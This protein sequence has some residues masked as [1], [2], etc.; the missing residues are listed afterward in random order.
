MVIHFPRNLA[1]N[2]KTSI[3]HN[4]IGYRGTKQPSFFERIWCHMANYAHRSRE[5]S[6]LGKY[7]ASALTHA[8]AA[9][10]IVNLAIDL[11]ETDPEHGRSSKLH[12]DGERAYDAL[13]QLYYDLD[14]AGCDLE[15]LGAEVSGIVSA[16]SAPHVTRLETALRAAVGEARQVYGACAKL[17]AGLREHIAPEIAEAPQWRQDVLIDTVSIAT[18]EARAA[19]SVLHRMLVMIE[20]PD[21]GG[22][23]EQPQ[24]ELTRGESLRSRGASERMGGLVNFGS[25]EDSKAQEEPVDEVIG[26]YS[27]RHHLHTRE[28][29]KPGGGSTSGSGS[30]S[31][32]SGD[33]GAASGTNRMDA[34]SFM[35][36]LTY[37]VNEGKT[38]IPTPWDDEED[39]G[40]TFR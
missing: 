10:S 29:T 9:T 12:S 23:G 16:P 3:K 19:R 36:S 38:P 27:I 13:D 34:S 35:R 33:T 31:G 1:D 21:G 20:R 18:F 15:S 2:Q 25:G 39:V 40:P 22:A 30:T 11:I 28:G 37:E 8:G 14:D 26:G 5:L 17:H 24:R 32:G 7:A 4:R 6:E